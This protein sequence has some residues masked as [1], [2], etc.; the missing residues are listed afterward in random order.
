MLILRRKV[1]PVR[2]EGRTGQAETRR[3]ESWLIDRE[4]VYRVLSSRADHA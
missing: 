3:L 4:N 2:A 1:K